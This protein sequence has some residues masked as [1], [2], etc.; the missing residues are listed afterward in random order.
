MSDE[1]ITTVTRVVP[2]L[3]VYYGDSVQSAQMLLEGAVGDA[4]GDYTL[5]NQN[6]KAVNAYIKARGAIADLIEKAVAGQDVVSLWDPFSE[7]D[8]LDTKLQVVQAR[9]EFTAITTSEQAA[10]ALYQSGMTYSDI[11]H[12]TGL[13]PRELKRLIKK[14]GVSRSLKKSVPVAT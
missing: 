14:R 2:D 5:L 7:Q 13:P 8:P 3:V 10:V 11:A 1:Q 6:L 9:A 4:A 12:H